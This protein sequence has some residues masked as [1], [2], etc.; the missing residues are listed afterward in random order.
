MA[1]AW[2]RRR[3]LSRF[4]AGR[5]IWTDQGYRCPKLLDWFQERADWTLDIVSRNHH[6]EGFEVLH[7]LW[8]V[9]RTFVWLGSVAFIV[10]ASAKTMKA[11]PTPWKP[12]SGSL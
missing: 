3:G 7:W 8:I 1:P 12:G 6:N 11:C 9:E 5:G 10:F 2:Y 4:R